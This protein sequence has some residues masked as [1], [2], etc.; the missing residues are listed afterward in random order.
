MAL[1][2][3]L[4]L[5]MTPLHPLYAAFNVISGDYCES[6]IDIDLAG[7]KL[8]RF[9]NGPEEQQQLAG[10]GWHFNHPNIATVERYAPGI[11]PWEYHFD[12]RHRLV[13]LESSGGPAKRLDILV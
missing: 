12:E 8:E 6:H 7:L 13:R 1:F 9:Y 5:L 4:S 10:V 3:I 2:I 11:S